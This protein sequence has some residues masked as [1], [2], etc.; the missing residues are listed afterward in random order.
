MEK[1]R[2]AVD[3]EY[4]EQCERVEQSTEM[5]IKLGNENSDHHHSLVIIIVMPR[6][7]DRLHQEPSHPVQESEGQE[8]DQVQECGQEPE[9]T[10]SSQELQ[11]T[12]TGQ[13]NQ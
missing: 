9:Q 5:E 10:Q 2:R 11:Q 6:S 4:R 12:G 13:I 1:R 3:R 8:R 7:H